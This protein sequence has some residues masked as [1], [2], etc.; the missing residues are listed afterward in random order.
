MLPCSENEEPDRN[1]E[2]LTDEEIYSA[3][4]Y[5]E[6]DSRTDEYLE[7]DSS[8]N[9]QDRDSGIGI[10]ICSYIAMVGCLGFV[11]IYWR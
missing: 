7:P 9:E 11:W 2:E 6:S 1:I 4:S 10:F 3:I 5:L 8:A